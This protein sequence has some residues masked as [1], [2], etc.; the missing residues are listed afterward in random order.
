MYKFRIFSDDPD[1]KDQFYSYDDK[2]IGQRSMQLTCECHN[3][4]KVDEWNWEEVVD[5]EIE[6]A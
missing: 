2:A 3:T 4:L 6:L 5:T 1:V